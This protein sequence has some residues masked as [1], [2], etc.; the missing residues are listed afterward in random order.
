MSRSRWFMAASCSWAGVLALVA[1]ACGDSVTGV[2]T[3]EPV[4]NVDGGGDAQTADQSNTVPQK[5][6]SG[7]PDADQKPDT[8]GIDGGPPNASLTELDFSEVN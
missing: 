3:P 4:T 7:L 6:A 5:D 2:D 8:S 1:V